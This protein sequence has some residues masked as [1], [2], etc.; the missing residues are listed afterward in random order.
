MLDVV[1]EEFLSCH[2]QGQKY[3]CIL[4]AS[5]RHVL[6]ALGNPL[7]NREKVQFSIRLNPERLTPSSDYMVV[8]LRVNT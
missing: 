4:D 8:T 2:F 3:S 6:C 1:N 7:T 5:K